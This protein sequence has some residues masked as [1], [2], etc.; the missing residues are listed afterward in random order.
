M[1][2][3]ENSKLHFTGEDEEEDLEITLPK[4]CG[5]EDDED[6]NIADGIL[7]ITT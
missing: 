4:E 5:T 2:A 6:K 3:S 1:R 7:A